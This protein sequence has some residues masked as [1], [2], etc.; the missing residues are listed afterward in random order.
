MYWESVIFYST[1]ELFRLLGRKL[2]AEISVLEQHSPRPI[3]PDWLK[4]KRVPVKNN[5]LQIAIAIPSFQQDTYLKNN[6]ESIIQQ[7]GPS[8][9]KRV[10]IGVGDGGSL[11]DSLQIIKKHHLNLTYWYSEKDDGQAS[12]VNRVFQGIFTQVEYGANDVMAWLNSD[13]LYFGGTLT[14]VLDEFEKDPELDLL[15][16]DRIIINESNKVVGRWTLPPFHPRVVGWSCYVPQETMFW[17]KRLWD[18][19]GGLDE[20]FEFA[21]DWDFIAKCVSSGAKVK[22]IP[23]YLGAFRV[24]SHQKSKTLKETTGR[25]EF[26]KIR[27]R[28][29]QKMHSRIF[30][31]VE[32]CFFYCQSYC[33]TLRRRCECWLSSS[34]G[35][36]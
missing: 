25:R 20:K 2:G 6:L 12:A 5:Q 26:S 35:E 17:R 28:L 21:M 3:P 8:L 9:S 16:S 22:H 23:E 27:S 29:P 14:R 33:C 30:R 34:R 13:D 4:P 32:R 11:D 19:V 24:H 31:M 15:Y 7:A 18:K 10:H 36:A 1:R